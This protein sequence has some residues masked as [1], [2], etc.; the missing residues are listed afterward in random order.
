MTQQEFDS[1]S[2]GAGM[3]VNYRGVTYAVAAV[4]FK[5]RLLGLSDEADFDDESDKDL[6]WVRCE[7]VEIVK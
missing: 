3:S 6:I 1:V 7:S 2:F 4:S 5:E